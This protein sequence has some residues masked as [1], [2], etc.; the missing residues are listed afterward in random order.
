[1][2]YVGV[3][4]IRKY[5]TGKNCIQDSAKTHSKTVPEYKLIIG[6]FFLQS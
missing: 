2:L 4:S 3:Y 6:M 5:S 1:M